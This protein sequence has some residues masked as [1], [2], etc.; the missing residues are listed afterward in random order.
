MTWNKIASDL[1][2]SNTVYDNVQLLLPE[3]TTTICVPKIVKLTLK[4]LEN[5]LVKSKNRIII[6]YPEKIYLPVLT[7]LFQTLSDILLEKQGNHSDFDSLKKGQKLKIDNSVCEFISS[8]NDR[9]KVKWAD[10]DNSFLKSNFPAFQK[11]ET[12]RRLSKF[13]GGLLKE[14]TKFSVIDALKQNMS[15]LKKSIIY[16]TSESKFMRITNDIKFDNYYIKD[17]LLFGKIKTDNTIDIINKG[18]IHGIPAVLFTN[19]L[20]SINNQHLENIKYIFVDYSDNIVNNQLDILDELIKNDFSIVIM[21]DYINS[22]CFENIENREFIT[23]RWDK[24]SLIPISDELLTDIINQKITNCCNKCINYILCENAEISN[25][26]IIMKNIRYI[27][28]NTNQTLIDLY[29]QLYDIIVLLLHKT[30]ILSL[31]SRNNLLVNIEAINNELRN[32]SYSI[33]SENMDNLISIIKTLKMILGDT[34]HS[35]KTDATE[36]I[37]KSSVNDNIIIIPD[38]EDK[39][40]YIIYW[41]NYIKETDKSITIMYAQEYSNRLHCTKTDVIVCGWLGKNRMKNIIFCNNESIIYVLLNE[42]ELQWKKSHISEWEKIYNNES[43]R[44]FDRYFTSIELQPIIND[45]NKPDESSEDIDDIRNSIQRN[46]YKKYLSQNSGNISIEAVPI[47]FVSG[48]FTFYKKSSNVI[49]VTD[50]I[51]DISE[52]SKANI[53]SATDIQ[54]GDFIVIRETERSLIREL[55]DDILEKDGKKEYREMSGR[56]KNKLNEK[57]RFCSIKEL[58]EMITREGT[59]IGLQAFR[60]WIDDDDFIA[61]Q[62]KENL[63]YIS[64]ALNDNYLINNIERI[65]E[66]C[67]FVRAAHVRAGNEISN[68]LKNGIAKSLSNMSKIRRVDI[69]DPIDLQLDELGKVKILKVTSIG[70]PITVDI[71][72][73]NR[74]LSETPKEKYNIEGKSTRDIFMDNSFESGDCKN[75]GF[76]PDKD[77]IYRRIK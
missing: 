16:V 61:P 50:I 55:A 11:A 57:R 8:D 24:H 19:D 34:Y 13:P 38:N 4:L 65:W 43:R 66:I 37:I 44:E 77:K 23:L 28:E 31:Q 58:H 46:R 1:L 67:K 9:I 49:T 3:S 35:E 5:A 75:K 15:F 29:W 70:E 51:N 26:L 54:I 27:I 76:I 42:F 56:W 7:V 36:R 10:I 32:Q 18:Q 71:I 20:Y 22:F 40:E 17:L 2:G 39:N 52:N 59:K 63:L 45:E 21:S 6:V 64:V 73:T 41:N 53:K 25:I 69:W 14:C 68:R 12:K 60:S 72:H 48:F 30:I 62:D 47:E 74:L 33:S